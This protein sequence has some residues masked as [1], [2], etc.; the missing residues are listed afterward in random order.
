[1][2]INIQHEE[3]AKRFVAVVDDQECVLDYSV[4]SDGKTLNY[5]STFVPEKL[6]GQHIGDE[7]VQHAL[8]YAKADH[9][10]V[11]P[12]CPFVKRIIERFPEYA[13]LVKYK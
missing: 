5:Y 3:S 9:Y 11:I 2:K 10:Q 1:M 4:S 8:A 7:I 13:D 6:R 12:S